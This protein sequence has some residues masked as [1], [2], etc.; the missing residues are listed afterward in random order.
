MHDW[1]ENALHALVIYG[2]GIR[3]LAISPY[4]TFKNNILWS[5]VLLSIF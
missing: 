5:Y 2:T 4:C 3:I 1:M